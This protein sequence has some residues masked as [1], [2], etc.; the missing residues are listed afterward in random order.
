[1]PNYRIQGLT[2]S[3]GALTEDWANSGFDRATSERLKLP[4]ALN[5][6]LSFF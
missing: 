4:A 3:R 5:H 6:A 2:Q 1:M